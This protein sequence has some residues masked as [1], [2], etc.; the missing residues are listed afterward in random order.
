T[1][2]AGHVLGIA[3][4]GDL[5]RNFGNEYYMTFKSVGGVMSIDFCKLPPTATVADALAQMIE[6]HQSCVV[7][8]D[9]KGH[10]V[11]VLTERDIV[12]LCK[13]HADPQQLTLS[14]AMHAPVR[15]VGPDARLHE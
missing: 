12:R 8:A 14:E 7:V 2:E 9:A 15:T 4:E 13:E 6:A 3:S 1:D 10:P 5:M 11:G